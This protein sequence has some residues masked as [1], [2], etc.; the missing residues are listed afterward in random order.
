MTFDPDPEDVPSVLRDL[1]NEYTDGEVFKALKALTRTEKYQWVMAVGPSD[2][3]KIT[4]FFGPKKTFKAV[5]H[6]DIV[7]VSFSRIYS[8]S[9]RRLYLGDT[10]NIRV[11]ANVHCL[12]KMQCMMYGIA[13]TWALTTEINSGYLD[14]INEKLISGSARGHA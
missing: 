9:D 1:S 7:D 6:D 14:E 13:Y 5:R 8:W 12:N 4:E 10:G 2:E 11:P 3:W